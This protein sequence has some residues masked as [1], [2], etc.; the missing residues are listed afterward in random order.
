MVDVA[1]RRDRL[2]ILAQMLALARDPITASNIMY[3]LHLS[4]TQTFEYVDLLL[5]MKLFAL[6]NSN[7]T[8]KNQAVYK[9]TRKGL[10]YLRNYIEI[11]DLVHEPDEVET[12]KRQIKVSNRGGTEE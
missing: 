8:K 12:I 6:I 1:R 4:A 3:T 9:T 10:Q 2:A 7:A 11:I 5:Y